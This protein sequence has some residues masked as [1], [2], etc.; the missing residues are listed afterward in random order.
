MGAKVFKTDASYQLFITFYDDYQ[1]KDGHLSTPAGL[2]TTPDRQYTYSGFTTAIGWALSNTDA[3]IEIPDWAHYYSIDITKCLRTRFFLQ[4]RAR[5]TSYAVKGTGGTYTFTTSAYAATLD[6]CAFDIGGLVPLNMGYSFTPG[7]IVK[8]YIGTNVYSLAITAQQGSWIITELKNLG[9]LNSSTQLLFEIYTPYKPSTSEP[10]FEVSQIFPVLNP[11]TNSRAYST[12][13]GLING[14]VWLITRTDSIGSYVVEA[15]SPNDKFYQN[16]FTDAGRPN[17]TD[18]IGQVVQQNSI[19]Y[20][21]TFVAGSKINGLSTFDALDTAD[22]PLECGP[23]EK[24]QLTSKVA[25]QG[26]GA[27]MLAICRQEV[28]SLYLGEVQ[29]VAQSQNAFLSSSPGVIGTVNVLKGSMGTRN[30]ESVQEFK[31]NV[32]W[33]SADNGKYV[34]YGPNGLFPISNYNMTKF[35]KLFCETYLSLT[36]I[37]IENL[38]SRPFVFTGID[39]HNGELLVSVPRVLVDPPKGYLPD[40]P[41]IPYPFDIWDG[42]AKAVVYKMY[43]D[44]NYWQGS[45]E[46]PA[47]NFIYAGNSLFALKDGN[48]YQLNYEGNQCNFFGIQRYP[49]LMF[50]EN[51]EPEKPKVFDNITLSAN[52]V[53][54][55]S[56]FRTEDPYVQASDLKDFDP[57]DNKEGVFYCYLYN[58]KLTPGPT[59]RPIDNA[60]LLGAKMR[61]PALLVMLQWLPPLHFRFVNIGYSPSLGHSI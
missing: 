9:T 30:P 37:Q 53:P 12:L 14:D 47:E 42:Q 58:D 7:D 16:W 29:V 56:Y 40:Y 41:N 18:T 3:L 19:A 27:I 8:A 15:M 5:N 22:V 35:W 28:A 48:L 54:F 1:R 38:G 57:W 43:K 2:I 36:P 10:S 33:L 20:S 4:L 24:L 26:Q 31:G 34:Q 50:V 46:L 25:D 49:A 32:F 52:K 59:L 13:S 45:Y 21:N 55:L 51:Q 39:P 60:L 6:G 11:G 23:L 17:F 61:A 44:P